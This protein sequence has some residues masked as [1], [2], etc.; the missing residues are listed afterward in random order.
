MGNSSQK[1]TREEDD[2]DDQIL[3]DNFD[4]SS[5]QVLNF[6]GETVTVTWNKGRFME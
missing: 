3:N 2:P 1:K 6:P 5:Q 4:E